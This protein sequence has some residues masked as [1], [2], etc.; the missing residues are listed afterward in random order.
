[1]THSIIKY[2]QYD[3]DKYLNK[4]STIGA[5]S[6]LFSDN[7]VPYLHYRVAE[8][9]YCN[10]FGAENLARSDV[11][12]D[13]RLKK[14]GIGIKTFLERNRKSF[15]K[16]AE[17]NQQQKFYSHLN[18]L[19]K[20]LMIAELRNKRL[21]FTQIAYNIEELI[22]HCVVRNKIGFSLFE[23]PMK[24]IDPKNIKITS[25]PSSKSIMFNDGVCDYKFDISKSTL[26]KRFI[27]NEYFASIDVH[28]LADPLAELIK[29]D[30]AASRAKISEHIII[31]LYSFKNN[32]KTVFSK[33]GL[34][35][36]N[37]AGRKRDLDEVYLPYPSDLRAV[38]EN[39]F[40]NRDASFNVNLP[41]GKKILMKVS[42]DRGKALTSNPNKALGEWILRDILKIPQGTLLTYDMLLAIGIDAVVFE[43]IDGKYS[44]DFVEV[45][46]YEDFFYENI[47]VDE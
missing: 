39:F 23:E 10:V 37:A 31:P 18:T 12:A 30:L 1:M 11:S 13:A 20:T 28:I 42:Q 24:Y 8:N 9:V 38:F 32:V 26:Y 45:G 25:K 33:S 3:I 6:A 34:N 35:I 19:N 5:L 47:L 44:L 17:F 22:Y 27:I 15:E 46:G 40:P 29:L 14:Y 21:E 36:W 43:K 16:V 4:L 41:D 7:V 2:N